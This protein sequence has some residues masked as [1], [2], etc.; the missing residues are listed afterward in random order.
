M[1]TTWNSSATK[2]FER[3]ILRLLHE[4]DL[5][6]LPPAVYIE[7]AIN[8][9]GEKLTRVITEKCDFPYIGYIQYSTFVAYVNENGKARLADEPLK[10]DL[11]SKEYC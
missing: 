9:Q 8:T 4:S 5:R 10:N 11:V 7:G 3:D 6:C 2:E 1:I